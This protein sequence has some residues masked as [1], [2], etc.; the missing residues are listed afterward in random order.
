MLSLQTVALL[1]RPLIRGASRGERLAAAPMGRNAE[2]V[3]W[4]E[5][6]S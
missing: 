6:E 4:V 5:L 2:L 1:I 3:R